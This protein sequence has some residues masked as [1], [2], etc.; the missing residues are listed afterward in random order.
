MPG[1][2]CDHMCDVVDVQHVVKV[3][4]VDGYSDAHVASH[5]EEEWMLDL[6]SCK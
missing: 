1:T 5:F 4:G 2:V 3:R 6:S